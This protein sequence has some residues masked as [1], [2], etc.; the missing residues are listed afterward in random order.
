[1]SNDE[2]LQYIRDYL[3]QY[4]DE[5]LITDIE[6]IKANNLDFTFPYVLLVSSGIDFLGGLTKGFERNNS[7]ERSRYFIEE[8]MGQVNKLYTDKRISD[9][10]YGSV[11]CGASHQGMYKVEVESSSWLY[12]KEKH[13]HHMT[14]F[15]GRDRI[16]IH[17]LQFADDFISAQKSYRDEYISQNID[18]VHQNLNSI[19]QVMEIEDFQSLVTELKGQG[20]TF[21]AK[22]MAQQNPRVTGIDTPSSRVTRGDGM[23]STTTATQDSSHST[24]TS[25]A[26]TRL[27]DDSEE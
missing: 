11:R 14:D 13:L 5:M 4:F 27:P 25:Y 18:P 26:V 17:A 15:H 7:R 9:I 6:K 24:S 22:S 8:W 20:L 12:P 16:F 10:I 3:E 23:E 1:M 2:K 21:D 19:L